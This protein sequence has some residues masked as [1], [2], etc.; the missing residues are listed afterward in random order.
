MCERNGN[1]IRAVIHQLEFRKETSSDSDKDA[2]HR[3]EPF[4]VTKRLFANKGLSWNDACDLVFVDYHMIP[5]MVQEAYVHAGQDDMDAIAFAADSLSRGDEMTRR[6][7]QTQDWGLIPHAL[8]QPIMATKQ[9]PGG[10]PFQIFPQLLGKMSKQRKLVRQMGEIGRRVTG[11]DG[12]TMRLDYAGPLRCVLADRF[13]RDVAPFRETIAFMDGV[14]ITRDDWW[15]GLEETVC[16]NAMDDIPTATRSAF[17]RE[18]N[19]CHAD[20]DGFRQI[21]RKVKKTGKGTGK[22]MGKGTGKG[23]EKKQEQEQEQEE[24]EEEE[25]E[26]EEEHEEEEW[27]DAF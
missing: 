7:Y 14:G 24:Q 18:W 1:D 17:T 3:M 15:D 10:A 12:K 5:L 23:T 9:V 21:K 27:E 4:S 26:E 22:G 13:K 8:A 6:V 19:K 16:G 25:Q 20:G 2:S 11:R